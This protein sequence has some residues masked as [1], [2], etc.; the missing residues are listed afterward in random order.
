MG[1]FLLP[2]CHN[3]NKSI[4]LSLIYLV[5]IV[6]VLW[7]TNIVFSHSN[8]WVAYASLNIW[9]GGLYFSRIFAVNIKVAAIVFGVSL[10]LLIAL[11]SMGF[12]NAYFHDISLRNLNG[13]L[14][15][16]IQALIISSPI[17]CNLVISKILK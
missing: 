3:M 12:L 2:L 13:V 5:F 17:V 16:L 15:L 6:V 10:F 14:F 4:N 8:S 9:W 1:K 7:V 11:A